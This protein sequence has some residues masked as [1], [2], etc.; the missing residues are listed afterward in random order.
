[1]ILLNALFP[2]LALI[3]FGWGV[4]HWQITDAAFHR[5]SDKLVYFVFFPLMLF[6]KI[7]ASPLHFT[8]NWQYFPAAA[9]AVVL[10]CGLSLL[11]IRLRPVADFQ[12]GSFNQGCYRFNTYIGMAVLINA[13]G[14]T[15]VQLYGILI[16]LI[17]PLINVLCVSILIWYG[18]SE[19]S[20]GNRFAITLKHLMA[21]PLIIACLAGIAYSRLVGSF[22]SPIDNTLKLMSQV[23]LPL[24]L[25]SIGGSLS[26]ANLRSNFNLA[27]AAAGLKLVA[28]P[29][30][31]LCLLWL[32]GVSG[33]AFKVSMLFFAQPTSTAIYILSSQLNSDPELASAVIVLS[34][35]LSFGSMALVLLAVA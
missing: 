22:P 15:G 9:L 32:F 24:A 17:I 2:V 10:V 33:L 8:D 1:M 6:W 26:F 7:G 14:Q 21:N 11:Y 29:L 28:L 27:L 19:T 16:G 35:L 34:T 20:H 12:A 4:R 25:F 18:G 13:F 23:T 31:G 5:V 3:V 30:V